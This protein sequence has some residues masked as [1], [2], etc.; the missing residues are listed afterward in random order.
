MVKNIISFFL[1]ALLVACSMSGK[2]SRKYE[3]EGVEVLSR[4]LGAPKSTIVLENGNK[5]YVYEKE[6]YVKETQ[7]GTGRG[8]LD[9]RISPSFVKVEVFRFEV[10]SKGVIVHTEYNKKVE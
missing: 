5:L 2:L 8:T 10:D 7:I 9:P 3:G 4:E 1:L 6:T